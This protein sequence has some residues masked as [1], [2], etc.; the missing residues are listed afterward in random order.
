MA[1]CFADASLEV[2]RNTPVHDQILASDVTGPVRE[3]KRRGFGNLIYCADSAERKSRKH[4]F[5]VW[6]AVDEAWKD[7]VHTNVGAGVTVCIKLGKRRKAC[8][9]RA[10]NRQ[11]LFWLERSEGG[12]I[13]PGAA[14]SLLQDGC[15]RPGQP[16]DIQNQHIQALMPGF[17]IDCQQITFWGVGCMTDNGVNAAKTLHWGPDKF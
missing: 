4:R 11:R 13:D 9:Q 15:D 7:V 5:V 10:G 2:T 12:Y 14:S 16:D 3:K 6:E 1:F 17:V 8:A